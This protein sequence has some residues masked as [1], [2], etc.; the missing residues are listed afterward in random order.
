MNAAINEIVIAAINANEYDPVNVLF[1]NSD[2]AEANNGIL[3][4]LILICVLIFEL[5][6]DAMLINGIASIAIM[7]K[8]I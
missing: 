5:V 1:N 2:N 6:F 4:L 8:I 3:F 7:N